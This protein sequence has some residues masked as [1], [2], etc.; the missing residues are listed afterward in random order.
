MSKE[1]FVQQDTN[2]VWKYSTQ[3]RGQIPEHTH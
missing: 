2:T 1:D 3:V